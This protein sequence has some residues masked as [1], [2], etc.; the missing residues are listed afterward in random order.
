MAFSGYLIS[1]GSNPEKF[2]E[3]FIVC[4][5]YKVSKKIIDLNSYRD[6]NGEL[7]RNALD[8]VSYTI[9]FDVKPMNNTR[10]QTFL[11]GIR[12]NFSIPKERKVSVTFYNPESDSYVTSDF[13]MPDPEFT[14]EKIENGQVYFKTTTIKFIGY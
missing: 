5:S 3:K 12:S 9:T 1:I 4:Q 2:F 8:H 13:Y 6:G 11:D 7:K 10:M 14:I